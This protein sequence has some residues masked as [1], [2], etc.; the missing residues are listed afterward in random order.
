M[1]DVVVIDAVRTPIGSFGGTLKSLAATDLGAITAGDLFKSNS[2]NPDYIDEVVMGNVLSAGLGQAPARQAALRAGLKN[3]TPC[4]LCD[5][6]MSA[7]M[8]AMHHIQTGDAGVMIAGGMESMSNVPLYTTGSRF[9]A[10]IGHAKLQDG[11]IKDGLSDSFKHFLMGNA[12][13]LCART[14]AISRQDQDEYAARSYK[15]ALYAREN[16]LL[17]N[18]ISRVKIRNSSKRQA[19]IILTDEEID[20]FDSEKLTKLPPEFEKEGTITAAN[21]SPLSDGAASLLLMSADRA[22]QLG[23]KPVARL[24]SQANAA[25]ATEWFTTS[26]SKA[27]ALALDRAKKTAADMDLFEIDEAF[28]IVPLVTA[29]LLNLNIEKVNV[30]GGSISLGNPIG[31]T[32]ARLLVTLY[33]ALR[34]RDKQW[35]CAGAC[36]GGGGAAA[37]VMERIE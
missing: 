31:C 12:A 27:M 1:N 37:M 11:I 7:V 20:R 8:I 5:S 23:C 19:E 3:T 35:G 26:P 16:G 21:A 17:Q 18:E 9:A 33:H 10:K 28:A 24:V 30:H 14:H 6:G 34:T 32:G 25:Q 36:L 13:E 4:S 2:L 15:Q 22:R 29:K